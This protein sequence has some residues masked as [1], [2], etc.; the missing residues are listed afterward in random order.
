[1]ALIKCTE[2]D[3][4]ISSKAASCPHCGNPM[5]EGVKSSESTSQNGTYCQS[6]KQYVTPVVTSVGGGTCSF[7]KR[8]TWKCPKCTRV[9]HRS[10]CFVATV[11]YGDEDMV[12]V[13]FLRAFRDEVL[14]KSLFG[15]LLIWLYYRVGPYFARIVEI[16]PP[17]QSLSRRVLDQVVLTIEKRTY[18]CRSSFRKP[19]P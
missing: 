3:K 6:C 12:E 16:Y 14:S 13:R 10:G 8:E 17:L 5:A 19:L 9:L 1:M 4:E 15:K 7:G 11:T 18:L 2:C